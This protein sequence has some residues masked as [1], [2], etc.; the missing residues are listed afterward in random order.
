MRGSNINHS[1]LKEHKDE[2]IDYTVTDQALKLFDQYV[3]ESCHS[4]PSPIRDAIKKAFA[5]RYRDT[6]HDTTQEYLRKGNFVRIYPSPNSDI[7][8]QYFSSPRPYN[9]IVY[10]ALFSDELIETNIPSTIKAI[11]PIEIKPISL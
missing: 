11:K 3:K 9:Y 7:Y 8:D 6:V 10:K 1:P 5:F 2:L 4:L